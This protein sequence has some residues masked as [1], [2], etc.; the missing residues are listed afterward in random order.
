MRCNL[1]CMLV[2]R[3]SQ[4]GPRPELHKADGATR[5]PLPHGMVRS[6]LIDR[7]FLL[8]NRTAGPL[9][10]LPKA[11]S[12]PPRP[13]LTGDLSA[14][15][16]LTVL[17]LLLLLLL[18]G[19]AMADERQERDGGRE[20]SLP[21]PP[22]APAVHRP[23]QRLLRVAAGRAHHTTSPCSSNFIPGQNSFPLAPQ[24][25]QQQQQQQ[26][27]RQDSFPLPACHE[28]QHQQEQRKQQE[29]KQRKEKEGSSADARVP[30][31]SMDGSSSNSGSSTSLDLFSP[32]TP[33][34]PSSLHRS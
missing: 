23:R 16:V 2:W 32:P 13:T 17:P 33:S 22:G 10:P 19:D 24:Y 21:A 26:L 5:R 18:L 27:P 4:V 1:R 31:C 30:P 14:A 29:Q 3:L 8:H 9:P 11:A 25:E 34:T 7:P 20:G 15:L 6:S 12:R 28:L